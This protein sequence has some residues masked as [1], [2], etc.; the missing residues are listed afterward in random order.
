MRR[1][2]GCNDAG[3][4]EEGGDDYGD[5]KRRRNKRG[6]RLELGGLGVEERSCMLKQ[7]SNESEWEKNVFL[8]LNGEIQLQI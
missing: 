5:T 2:K 4:G 6:R 3:T 1:G 8:H 7:S